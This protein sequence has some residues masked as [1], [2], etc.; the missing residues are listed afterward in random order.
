MVAMVA[1][2]ITCTWNSRPLECDGGG[3]AV[4][5]AAAA[6]GRPPSRRDQDAGAIAFRRCL[7]AAPYHG[8]PMDAVGPA[9][10]LLP[11]NCRV[12]SQRNRAVVTGPGA[13]GALTCQLVL[14]WQRHPAALAYATRVIVQRP[15][16][17]A[18]GGPLGREREVLAIVT[19]PFYRCAITYRVIALARGAPGGALVRVD[20]TDPLIIVA[21]G[22]PWP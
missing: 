8:V 7:A 12:V 13:N 14:S 9:G 1:A 6:A 4:A 10:L 5:R 17:R 18:R 20:S 16:T 22:G 21:E 15:C 3:S 2:V 19:S 11:T